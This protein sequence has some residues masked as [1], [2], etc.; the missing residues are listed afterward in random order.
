MEPF[1]FSSE[2]QRKLVKLALVDDGFCST[3][4]KYCRAEMFD[5]DALRWCWSAISRERESGRTPTLMVLRDLI[6]KAP[7]VVQPRYHAMLDAI[8]NDVLREDSYIRHSLGEFVRR[9]MFVEA[10]QA[11][12]RIYNL[13]KPDEAVNLAADAFEN[14]RQVSFD[15]PRRFDFFDDLSE[16]DRRRTNR[17]E[18]EWESTFPTG[19]EGVDEVLDGGLSIGEL[20]C[21]MADAK[22]GKSLF[23]IHLAGYT[24]RVLQRKVLFVLLEGDYLQTASRFD[25]WFSGSAYQTVKRSD[26][27]ASV[28][29][30]LH[31][32]YRMLRGLLIIRE[33]T[34][35]AYT[36]RDIRSEL[37]EMKAQHGWVPSQIVVDYGDLL[38]SSTKAAS[39]EEHQRNAFGEMKALCHTGSGYSLWTATQARRPAEVVKRGK[40]SDEGSLNK[41]GKFVLGPKDISDSYNKVRRV[42]FL[43]SINQDAEDKAEGTARLYCAVYRDNE[44]DRLVKIRQHL[45]RSRF[46]DTLDPLNHPNTPEDLAQE[47]AKSTRAEMAKK[48]VSTKRSN[49]PDNSAQQDLSA[50]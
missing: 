9:N 43:G 50:K 39:E 4:L 30:Q 44:A 31:E 28:L 40:N 1:K 8:E 35:S 20:G 11:S 12:Q 34:D 25:A 16:R 26:W 22:G 10:Y 19:I 2:F 3:S 27:S 6:S 47:I 7:V 24:C 17:S 21:W 15:S 36:V 42:D 32:E 38:R 5:S 41:F 29:R 48:K 13:G 18:R 45:N 33:M 14:I 37:D 49:A 23:L 46:V